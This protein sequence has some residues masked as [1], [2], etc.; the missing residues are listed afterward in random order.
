[1]IYYLDFLFDVPLKVKEVKVLYVA[2]IRHV[3]LLFEL[4]YSTI[5][6]I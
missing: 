4:E 3:S 2:I 1:M 5:V 6:L